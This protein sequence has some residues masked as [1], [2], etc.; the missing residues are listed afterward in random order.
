MVAKT[1]CAPSP[2]MS[3]SK[4]YFMIKQFMIAVGLCLMAGFFC[5]PLSAQSTTPVCGGTAKTEKSGSMSFTIGQ[6][7]YLYSHS[8]IASSVAGVQQPFDENLL[9]HETCDGV[10]LS[11][12]P[13]P[14]VGDIFIISE[15]QDA[16][17]PYILTDVSGRVWQEGHL[18][19]EYTTIPM[20]AVVRGTYL[21]KIICGE[22]KK[23]FSVFK[24]IKN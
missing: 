3:K 9:F 4:T 20:D 1:V 6:V 2:R 18:D 15:E 21:L 11:L 22:G 17:Y 5:A 8:N 14:T 12:Y 10:E 7:D 16:Q 24:V 13:N 19:G 23:D